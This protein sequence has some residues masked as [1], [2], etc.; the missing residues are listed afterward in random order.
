MVARRQEHTRDEL[1]AMVVTAA[2]EI[3]AAEGL[4]G[5][6]MRRLAAAVGYAPNSI[7][8]AVGDMDEIVLRLNARTLDLLCWSLRRCLA[9]ALTPEFRGGC[10][11]RR[12][13]CLRPPPPG[14]L[15][16]DRRVCAAREGTVSGLVPGGAVAAA[17]TGRRGP[18]AVLRRSRRPAALHGRAVGGAPRHRVADAVRQ[19]RRRH[20]RRR[21][22]ARAAGGPPLPRGRGR[23]SDPPGAGAGAGRCRASRLSPGMARRKVRQTGLA[24]CSS[25]SDTA[26]RGRSKARSRRPSTVATS[27]SGSS[28]ASA[29][30]SRSRASSTSSGGCGAPRLSQSAWALE[31]VASMRWCRQA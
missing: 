3:A 15:V 27:R 4:A 23:H 2:E 22:A 21:P 8:H 13:H 12:L 16:G 17:G 26:W 14:P 1:A 6:T 5:V 24:G 10:D 19:A 7:Y 11:R 18:D 30:A 25:T 9:G 31:W 29:A 28:S 20:Q